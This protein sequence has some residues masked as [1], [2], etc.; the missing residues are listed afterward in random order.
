MRNIKKADLD[1]VLN[2]LNHGFD[3]EK[4]RVYP[5][6]GYYYL[7]GAYGGHKL[8][9]IITAGGGVRDVLTHVGYG[10]KRDLYNGMQSLLEGRREESIEEHYKINQVRQEYF[11]K[12]A[13]NSR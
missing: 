8:V 10:T 1:S 2:L 7:E 5:E 6:P 11:D 4:K 3:P 13:K 9:Q 12:K